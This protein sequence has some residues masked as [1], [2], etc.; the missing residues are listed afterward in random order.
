MLFSFST[1]LMALLTSIVMAILLAVPFLRKNL[2]PCIGYKSLSVFVVLALLRLTLPFEFPFTSNILLSQALSEIIVFF[3]HPR[4]HVMGIGIS[5]W[6]VLKIVWIAGIIISL[7][8]AVRKHYRGRDYIA[9]RGIDKTDDPKYK[10]V[11]DDICREHHKDNRFRVIELP[12]LAVPAIWGTWNPC[13]ILPAALD[14]PPDNLRHILSHEA[15]HYFRYDPFIKKAVHLLSIIYWWNPVCVFLYKHSSLL[16]EMYVD[17]AITKGDSNLVVEYTECL[18]DAKKQGLLISNKATESIGK[19][20]CSLLQLHDND[21]GR[22]A[23]MLLKKPPVFQKIVANALFA[24]LIA[25]VLAWSYLH[26]FEASYY[27]P[28]AEGEIAFI[29]TPENAYI[30]VDEFSQYKVYINDIYIE[31]VSSLEFYLN[32]I[33]IYNQ[34]GEQIGET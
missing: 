18:L 8:N 12:D 34:E 19:D 20:A 7:L 25:F 23:A 4:V 11:L 26:I 6:T 33:K 27:P 13:I 5:L 16:L 21:L 1:V 30:I 10:P 2:T 31:T 32:G 3:R 9:K 15:M 29:P 28:P 17:Q 14:I 22:R 24:G